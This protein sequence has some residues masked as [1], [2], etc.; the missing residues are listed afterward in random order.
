[1]KTDRAVLP[2]LQADMWCAN[3]VLAG[4]STPDQ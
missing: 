2:S 4:P 1:M 3:Y